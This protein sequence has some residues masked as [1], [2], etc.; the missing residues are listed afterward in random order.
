MTI[1]F[2][3][4]ISLS[5]TDVQST[6]C[7]IQ[8]VTNTRFLFNK[9]GVNYF[10]SVYTFRIIDSALYI[11]GQ[12]KPLISL[13]IIIIICQDFYPQP[14]GAGGVVMESRYYTRIV[15]HIKLLSHL[16]GESVLSSTAEPLYGFWEERGKTIPA[17]Q[18]PSNMAASISSILGL[19]TPSYTPSIV[20]SLSFIPLLPKATIT[21][22]VQT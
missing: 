15:T 8:L 3:Y 11:C 9:H 5:T 6:R 22:S 18:E 7:K 4:Y 1:F 17:A 2:T 20:S 12:L 19:S 14:R 10:Y 16:R 21:L 13:Q